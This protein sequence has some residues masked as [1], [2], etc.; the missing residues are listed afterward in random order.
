MIDRL[1]SF[2]GITDFDR[3]ILAYGE[4]YGDQFDKM[5]TSQ[6]LELALREGF[7]LGQ[8]R[9][10]LGELLSYTPIPRLLKECFPGCKVYVCES[11]FS[12]VLFANHPHVDSITTLPGRD[13]IGAW[14]EFGWGNQVQRRLRTFGIFLSYP[15]KPELY[16]SAEQKERAREWR[17]SLPLQGRPLLA[18]HSSG[19]TNRKLLNH[20]EWW[21]VYQKLKRDFFIVQVGHYRDQWIPAHRHQLFPASLPRTIEALSVVDAFLGPDSGLM[22]L[23]TAMDRNCVVLHNEDEGDGYYLPA[24]SDEGRLPSS[25]PNYRQLFPWQRQL[26]VVRDHPEADL[27]PSAERFNPDTLAQTLQDASRGRENPAWSAV[28]ERFGRRVYCRFK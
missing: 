13:P 12:K 27:G 2:Y 1:L 11:D 15:E 19:R 9:S 25:R 20:L 26:V 3:Q 8:P 14:R 7:Y 22:H 28:R 10:A 4:T 16:L 24:L 6:E 18:I 21:R 5:L 23:A 17:A